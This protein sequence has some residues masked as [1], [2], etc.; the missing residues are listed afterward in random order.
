M[1]SPRPGRVSAGETC[2]APHPERPEVTCDR[3]DHGNAGYHR[4]LAAGEGEVWGADPLPDV[5]RKRR[6]EL[7]AMASRT[8]RPV[9][10]GPASGVLQGKN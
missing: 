6:P 10:T 5:R 7:A 1:S 4:N 3:E 9:S 2:G 8:A